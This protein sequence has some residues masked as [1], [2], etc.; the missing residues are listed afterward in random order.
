MC[1]YHVHSISSCI[2]FCILADSLTCKR[3]DLQLSAFSEPTLIALFS[4]S[5]LSCT[6]NRNPIITRDH[7]TYRVQNLQDTFVSVE[8]SKSGRSLTIFPIFS[9][10]R[11][12]RL[13]LRCLDTHRA[14]T[15]RGQQR[16]RQSLMR[17]NGFGSPM[18]R[19]DISLGGS[20][21]RTMRLQRL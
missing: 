20:T 8:P 13:L 12:S 3:S 4:N 21:K 9:L 19:M 1:A 2:L 14:P 7:L 11:A 10:N 5:S 18:K 15:L 17:R 6:I 16:N